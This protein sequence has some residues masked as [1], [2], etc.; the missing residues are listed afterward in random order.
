MAQYVS[1]YD[2]RAYEVTSPATPA[3]NVKRAAEGQKEMMYS[4]LRSTSGERP[5]HNLDDRDHVRLS[6]TQP[7][8]SPPPP[9]PLRTRP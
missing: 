4:S 5:T 8:P 3:C 6:L 9:H 2:L 1:E 7:R